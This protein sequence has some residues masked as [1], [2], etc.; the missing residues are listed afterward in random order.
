MG[1]GVCG[2]GDQETCFTDT[3]VANNNRF[4][5][6]HSE[7]KFVVL[8]CCEEKYE[9]GY[10]YSAGA[11]VRRWLWRLEIGLGIFLVGC[12]RGIL[13]RLGD[14]IIRGIWGIGSIHFLLSDAFVAFCLVVLVSTLL[15]G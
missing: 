9:S 1:E 5:A 6:S 8:E 10:L 2:V 11:E 12:Q 14:K 13:G 15:C 3:S 7:V 4:Y